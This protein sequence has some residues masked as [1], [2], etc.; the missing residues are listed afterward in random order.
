MFVVVII[1]CAVPFLFSRPLTH[2]PGSLTLSPLRDHFL[3]QLAS[4]EEIIKG[5]SSGPLGEI[6][7]RYA[8]LRVYA[9]AVVLLPALFVSF[10]CA[11]MLVGGVL[12]FFPA[13]RDTLSPPTENTLTT[14]NRWALLWP[15]SPRSCNNVLYIRQIAEESE[16]TMDEGGDEA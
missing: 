16:S 2:S 14:A 9:A 5:K 1:F 12:F 13:Q 7:I 8:S 11:S 4:T 10:V 15:A 3:P 6:L